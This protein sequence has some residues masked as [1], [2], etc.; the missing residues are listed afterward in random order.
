MA[1]RTNTLSGRKPRHRDDWRTWTIGV[2]TGIATFAA[3]WY[4]ATHGVAVDWL[5]AS[6]ATI[7]C[8]LAGVVILKWQGRPQTAHS[9]VAKTLGFMLMGPFIVALALCLFYTVLPSDFATPIDRA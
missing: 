7:V 3:L 6:A 2:L 8:G 9:G 5:L 4:E 1:R